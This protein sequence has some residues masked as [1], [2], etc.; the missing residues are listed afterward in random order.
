MIWQHTLVTASEVLS[1]PLCGCNRRPARADDRVVQVAG[2]IAV[3]ADRF[4]QLIPSRLP[5]CSSSGSFGR[6]RRCCS[7]SCSAFSR[8]WSPA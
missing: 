1:V 4:F 7:L 3:P 2:A 8:R 5:R 6:F